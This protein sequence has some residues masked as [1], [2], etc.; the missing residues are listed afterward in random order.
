MKTKNS[1]RKASAF[2]KE[3][4]AHLRL[5]YINTSSGFKSD[6]EIDEMTTGFLQSLSL[7]N[8]TVHIRNDKSV[9][10]GILNFAKKVNAGLIGISTHGRSGISHFFNGS[11]SEDLVN[12]AHRPVLTYKI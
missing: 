6:D 1:I 11:I 2:A 9:E 7:E 4:G 5:L 8:Y 12:H 3:L 10:K